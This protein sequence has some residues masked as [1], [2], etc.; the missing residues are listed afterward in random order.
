MSQNESLLDVVVL[1]YKWKKHILGAAFIAAIL[2]AGASLMMPNYYE[3]H[4]L[5]YAA[6]PDI[7]KPMPIGANPDEK[8]I[9][10]QDTDLDR[11]FSI[12]KSNAVISYLQEKF[13]LYEHYEIKKDDKLAQ[14][15]LMLKLKKLYKTTKTK[16]EAIDLSV[17]DKD[18][19][20]SAEM[21]NAARIRIDEL[22]QQVTKETQ[23]K[24]LDAYTRGL[25]EKEIQYA[26][27]MDSLNKSIKKYGI[28]STDSQGESYGTAMVE[29]QGTFL[30]ASA[31]LEFLRKTGAPRDSIA[32]VQAQKTGY[33]R[34]LER[35][36]KDM[37]KFNA[38]FPIVKNLERATRDFSL[39][40][41]VDKDRL[42]S[43]KAVYDSKISAIHVVEQATTPVY[44][45]RP[46]RSILVLGVAFLTGIL[47]C[48]W[49]IIKD[50]YN[51]NNWREQF[52]NA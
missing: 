3:S 8:D 40:M 6:S 52:K 33:E 21:A 23:K 50:Q 35:L 45:S 9:Y 10:G 1:L 7:F 13:N 11:L 31:K 14:H 27:I 39:Q 47:M 29:V 5:F 18:P 34:Q 15:K 19:A 16:Y 41:N 46:K 28:F 38:G 48:L 22:A 20:F 25:K 32:K 17:E 42:A 44:K 2:T 51:K 49:V 37:D 30:D 24:Q 4:T 26:A 36:S 43:L 12:A